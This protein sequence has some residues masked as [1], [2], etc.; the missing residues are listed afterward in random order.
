MN[1]KTLDVKE[2]K[3]VTGGNGGGGGGV[4]PPEV[5]SQYS[6]SARSDTAMLYS[7]QGLNN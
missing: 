7:T 3:R 1:S 5:K 4:V 2:L 6:G